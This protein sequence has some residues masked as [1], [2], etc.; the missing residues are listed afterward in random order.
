MPAPIQNCN[1]S[2]RLWGRCTGL[3]VQ[4]RDAMALQSSQE[5]LGWMTTRSCKTY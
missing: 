5:W 3:A 2:F 4:V 1:P